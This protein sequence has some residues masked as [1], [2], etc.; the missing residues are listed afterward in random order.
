MRPVLL[1]LLGAL[2]LSACP[3]DDGNPPGSTF[4]R[5]KMR[6]FVQELAAHA[7]IA[8]PGF[9]VVPQNGQ[10]LLTT[11]GE[12]DGPPAADYIAAIDG[13]AR[14]DVFY[15]YRN[16]NQAT[17]LADRNYLLGWLRRA[18]AEGVE[19]LVADYCS[20]SSRMTD[21]YTR[22]AAEG[23]VSFAAP[24]R[25]L[26]T[27]PLGQ[28]WEVNALDVTT[29]AQARNMLYLLNP[30]NFNSKEAFIAALAATNYDLLIIDAFFNEEPLT[31]QD[32]AQLQLKD[33][34]GARIVLSYMS[35]GEAEDYRY[36]WEPTW[37]E[38]KPAWIGEENP[39][40]EGNYKVR[41]WLPEW[42]AIIFGSE[43]AYLDRIVAAGFDGVYLDII[44]AFEYFEE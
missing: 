5:E 30:E 31:A 28:P 19:V 11:D 35:I 17:P 39:E 10:E 6:E 34:G 18:E 43:D 9:L 37:R 29:L 26:D 20:T 25:D 15:G 12:D 42:Q 38:G 3:P 36:Y 21:S 33:N 8:Q 22:N 13:Q 14:E 1:L 23:F 32:V 16:D 44:D 41:Y 24:R 2:A 40:W 7:R 27:L 4:H